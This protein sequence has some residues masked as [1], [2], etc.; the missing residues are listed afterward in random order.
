M[1]QNIFPDIMKPNQCAFIEERLLLE[2][3]LLASELVNG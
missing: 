1:L 3:V 2:N